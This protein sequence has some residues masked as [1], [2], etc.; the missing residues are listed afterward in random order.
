MDNFEGP[1]LVKLTSFSVR[2]LPSYL[3]YLLSV[4][5]FPFQILLEWWFQLQRWFHLNSVRLPFLMEGAKA[6]AYAATSQR[7]L[8]LFVE[9]Y[10]ITLWLSPQRVL[11]FHLF[12]PKYRLMMDKILTS[13]ATEKEVICITLYLFCY[14][15]SIALPSL[16]LI[17]EEPASYLLYY[18][19]TL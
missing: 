12:V 11:L 18:W 15:L 7:Q 3:L 19:N 14:C 9:Y 16:L 5:P 1:H 10:C 13:K 8:L 6:F 17:Q 4:I 2:L